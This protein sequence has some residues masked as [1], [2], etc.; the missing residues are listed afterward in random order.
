MN[1]SSHIC[2]HI[3]KM[4]LMHLNV[5]EWHLLYRFSA[6]ALCLIR[7]WIIYHLNLNAS[8]IDA[9]NVILSI[10]L[11]NQ[12]IIILFKC[13][14]VYAMIYRHNWQVFVACLFQLILCK[15]YQITILVINLLSLPFY[16]QF[17]SISALFFLLS[18]NRSMPIR[19]LHSIKS[20]NIKWDRTKKWSACWILQILARTL[21]V[22]F[23]CNETAIIISNGIR[24]LKTYSIGWIA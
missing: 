17:T 23:K 24:R 3:F 11:A 5:W 14:I 7:C 9:L 1:F 10:L 21:S 15:I 2:S 12:W 22:Q 18:F 8:P 20:R 4:T 6:V 19:E 13:L 16:L